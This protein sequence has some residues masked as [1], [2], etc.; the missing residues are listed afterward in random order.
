MTMFDFLKRIVG[1]ISFDMR[2]MVLRIAMVTVFMAGLSRPLEAS[3]LEDTFSLYAG[4][5][6]TSSTLAVFTL[7]PLDF[8]CCSIGSGYKHLETME[9]NNS[10]CSVFHFTQR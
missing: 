7:I 9:S 1:A 8:T 5:V 2:S 6:L 3:I 4:I 10:A